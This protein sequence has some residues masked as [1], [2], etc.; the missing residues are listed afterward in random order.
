MVRVITIRDDVYERLSELK[1]RH[2]MSFSQAIE[3]LLNESTGTRE[4]LLEH[5]GILNETE[6]DR[7]MLRKMR[8]WE[9]S[10]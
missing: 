3:M 5:A 10:D 2:G 4:G 8:R 1:K 7:R 9:D 6:I